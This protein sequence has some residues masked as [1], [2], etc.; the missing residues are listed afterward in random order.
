MALWR[1]REMQKGEM[2]TDPIEGEFFSTELLES[3]SD[4]LVRE[5]IQN[6]LDA[7]LPDKTVEVCF[8]LITLPS[9]NLKNDAY[10]SGLMPHLQAKQSGLD[11]IP[12]A[13]APMQILTVEDFGTKGLEGDPLQSDDDTIQGTNGKNDFYYFWRN[14]GRSSKSQGD[15][16]RWGLGKT[17]FQATSKIN[18]FFGVSVRASDM[19]PFV[20]GHSVL[21]T[22]FVD[23][24]RCYPYGWFGKWDEAFP[25]P[26]TDKAFIG[27]FTESFQLHD[28]LARPGLSIV[29]PFPDETVTAEDIIN[30]TVTHYFYPLLAGS[31]VVKVSNGSKTVPVNELLTDAHI[32]RLNLKSKKMKKENLVNFIRFAKWAIAETDY[33]KLSNTN[34]LKPEW[35]EDMLSS[36]ELETL[37]QKFDEGKPIALHVPLQVKILKEP[38]KE[39]FFKIFV[40]R[41]EQLDTAEDHFIR[42]GITIVGVS[43][44][45]QRGVRVIVVVDDKPLSMLLGDSE[46]PAHT[47]W[48]ERSPKFKG[49]Y[50]KGPTC[51]R[52]VKNSS[53]EIVKLLS[54]PSVGKDLTL[55]SNIFSLYDPERQKRDIESIQKPGM[56]RPGE[57]P[58]DILLEDKNMRIQKVKGGFRVEPIDKTAEVPKRFI[59]SVAYEVRQGN[60]FSRYNR[61]DFELDKLPIERWV[62]N[63]KLFKHKPNSLMAYVGKNDFSFRITGF[64]VNRDIR[65]RL[66]TVV[67]GDA[68]EI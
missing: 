21:K 44:L 48:Q 52:F 28:R 24:K 17:V 18:T 15:R 32:A 50:D 47:E 36:Q 67:V 53:R 42:D 63:V 40:Q 26:V 30:S 33:V 45:K 46:N 23:G 9:L 57:E 5:S 19:I 54:K 37:R 2:N 49:K 62:K 58:P 25:L 65:V 27:F 11:N 68:A 31:L 43:T 41:D 7:G 3:M 51:L 8:R 29:V 34:S 13:N 16:G 56:D 64:D 1:F 55:L 59:V 6:S 4:A 61:L 60:P 10:F 22:H 14:V 66:E 35:S 39:T 38:P 12:P 20:M